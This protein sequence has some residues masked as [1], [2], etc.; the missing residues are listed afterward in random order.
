[1]ATK[2][3]TERLQSEITAKLKS[4]VID[5][6]TYSKTTVVLSWIW[7]AVGLWGFFIGATILLYLMTR[8]ILGPTLYGT[9]F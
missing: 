3:K 7:L 8:G 2:T 6:V 4:H 5:E 1:M 9:L